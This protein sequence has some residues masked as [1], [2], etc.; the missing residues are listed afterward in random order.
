MVKSAILKT[1]TVS[2]MIKPALFSMIALLLSSCILQPTC[3]NEILGQSVSPD[4][5]M[6]AVIFS[7]NCGATVGFNYQVSILASTKVPKGSGNVLIADQT[8][9]YSDTLKPIWRGNRSVLVPI[10]QGSRIF[11]KNDN[12]Q[13]VKV[14]FN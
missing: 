9:S 14:A 13:G 12:V 10:P 4:G 11:Y 8:P 7:R 3:E 5:K 2:V 1:I 6:T